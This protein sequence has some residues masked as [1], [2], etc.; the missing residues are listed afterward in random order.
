MKDLV[1]LWKAGYVVHN[2]FMETLDPEQNNVLHRQRRRHQSPVNHSRRQSPDIAT[3]DN[4]ALSHTATI[5]GQNATIQIHTHSAIAMHDA[6]TQT[7]ADEEI[8]TAA[9]IAA[10]H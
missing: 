6:S 7:D 2:A 9:W 1:L 8:Y 4:V 5:L 10:I 3:I